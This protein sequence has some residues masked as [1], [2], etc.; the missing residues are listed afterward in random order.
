M[1]T[2][3]A[4]SFGTRR[5]P[6]CDVSGIQS[7]HFLHV[8]TFKK[9]DINLVQ[10]YPAVHK[11]NPQFI[12]SL[13]TP[14]T[15]EKLAN[16]TRKYALHGVLRSIPLFSPKKSQGKMS[17]PFEIPGSLISAVGTAPQLE[18]PLPP[19][20]Q[21][22]PAPSAT[23]R[24]APGF[25]MRTLRKQLDALHAELDERYRQQTALFDQNQALFHYL[26]QLLKANQV[27]CVLVVFW[28]CLSLFGWGVEMD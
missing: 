17:H 22:C 18:L 10:V 5:F 9:M 11:T 19:A 13:K 28:L 2:L 6:F 16:F 21:K 20:L 24:Q 26:Q 27:S 1:L 8:S 4:H 7:R 15:S 23:R 25:D 12:R 14:K 3:Q